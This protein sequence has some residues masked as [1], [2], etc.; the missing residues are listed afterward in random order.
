MYDS[1]THTNNSDDCTQSL[2]G[3]CLSAIEKGL[4]G[5]SITDHVDIPS[6]EKTKAYDRILQSH[7]DVDEARIK[8]GDK[9]TIL[10]GV[11]IAEGFL[12]KEYSKKI[13][14][15]PDLDVVIGSVH[16]TLMGEV[17]D[18][19]S[20]IDFSP[21]TEEFLKSYFEKYLS[22]V[23]YTAKNMDIDILAHL[24]CP[25]RYINGK[26]HR[27]INVN[28]FADMVGEILSVI[29][30]RNIALEVNTSGMGSF[31]GEYM[32]PLNIVE[33]YFSIGGR[34]V[35]IGSDAHI[36]KNVGNAFAET[37]E[38]LKSIGFTEY[39][40]YKKRTPVGVKI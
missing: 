3:L 33:L 21:F 16:C 6:S 1:H 34:L 17:N 9:I 24:T 15:L 31:Y 27:G 32:P 22:E 37:K 10:K 36:A 23:L 20:K 7:K 11:E 25:L 19:Y 13:L 26:Y 5:I 30:E 38:K 12:D 40:Y 39:H 8:Y 14:A 2:D 18:F 35:T 29:I 28:D 4:S